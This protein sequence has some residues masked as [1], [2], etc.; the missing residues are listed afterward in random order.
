MNRPR[1]RAGRGPLIGLLA[2]FIA[3]AVVSWAVLREPVTVDPAVFD[4]PDA[5]R[6]FPTLDEDRIIGVRLRNPENGN[7]LVVQRIDADSPWTVREEVGENGL[8]V[9]DPLASVTD[10]ATATAA[11]AQT[12][13]PGPDDARLI[14]RTVAILPYLETIALPEDGDLRPFGYFPRGLFSIETV[15]DDGTTHAI[16]IGDVTASR[17]GFYALIDER[18]SL[19]LIPR[20]PI[21]YL[22]AQYARR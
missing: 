12:P 22:L 11:A 1:A 20:A 9:P 10:L 4:V 14:A 18:P 19:Y 6:A 5:F 13:P 16:E 15:L 21:D 2:V 7:A 8:P 3:L 17:S